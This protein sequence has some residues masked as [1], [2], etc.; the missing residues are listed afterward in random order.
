MYGD[1]A[2]VPSFAAAPYFDT[3]SLEE[4]VSVWVS[5]TRGYGGLVYYGA[6]KPG[7]YVLVA[8]ARGGVGMAA[9]QIAKSSDAV[10]IVTT[11][12]PVKADLL[13]SNGADHVVVLGEEPLSVGLDRISAGKGVDL[14]FNAFTGEIVDHIAGALDPSGTIIH[15][16]AIGQTVTQ[17]PWQPPL[18]KG[19]VLRDYTLFEQT[20][21]REP[22]P[23]FFDFVSEG[24]VTNAFKPQVD[25]VFAFED[26]AI[27]ACYVE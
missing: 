21:D 26:T 24:S 18:Q 23:A 13:R 22:I 8:A 10:P 2:I 17:L 9:L 3:L 25:R 27:A 7:D 19:A 20:F 15:Y 6:L 16:G 14:A 4:N 1:C 12:D 11:R 5:Y